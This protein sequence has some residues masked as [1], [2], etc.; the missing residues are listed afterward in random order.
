MATSGSASGIRARKGSFQH[1]LAGRGPEVPVHLSD[2]EFQFGTTGKPATL[3]EYCRPQVRLCARSKRK[4]SK[5]LGCR[6]Q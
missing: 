6:M 5:R 2:S 3:A 1:H 4:T